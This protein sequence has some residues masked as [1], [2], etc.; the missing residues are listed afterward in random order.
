MLRSAILFIFRRLQALFAKKSLILIHMLDLVVL[1]QIVV[2]VEV[3]LKML[4]VWF[5]VLFDA[6]LDMLS[7]DIFCTGI[8]HQFLLRLVIDG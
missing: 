8:N 1:E 6:I 4:I 5:I 7:I 3:V 2:S